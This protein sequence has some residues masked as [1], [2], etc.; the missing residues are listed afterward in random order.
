[1]L[2]RAARCRAAGVLIGASRR[3]CR[4]AA[5]AF[6]CTAVL[7]FV[8]QATEG[9]DESSP[10]AGHRTV[11]DATTYPW[12]AVGAMFNSGQT[13]CTAV[14]I[15]ADQILTA[16]HCLYVRRTGHL[17][18]AGSLHV[19]M[20]FVR[21]DYA[22]D[23]AVRSYHVGAAYA[24]NRPIGASNADWAVLNLKSRLPSGWGIAAL[25]KQIP[26]AG[27]PVMATGYGRDRAFMM[28]ADPECRI[29]GVAAT[30]ILLSNCHIAPG[31]SGGPL[32]ARASGSDKMEVVGINIGMS[33]V[34]GAQVAV[35]VPTPLIRWEL[36][37]VS[38]E[39]IEEPA[40]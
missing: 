20:G 14:A 19:L 28:T 37:T 10:D 26:K 36:E 3:L 40:K 9:A 4:V 11:V 38:K 18:A 7:G 25:A 30:G 35:A 24:H 33:I 13:E 17:V 8:P 15:A 16:A 31:Y 32:L 39:G 5:A 6:A 29:L 21:G 1:M 12:S 34:G 23:A 2:S 27:T 22:I